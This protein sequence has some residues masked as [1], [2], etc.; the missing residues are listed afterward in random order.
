[1]F[2]SVLFYY[3]KSKRNATIF[4]DINTTVC[5][6]PVVHER[7]LGNHTHVSVRDRLPVGRNFIAEDPGPADRLLLKICGTF[8]MASDELEKLQKDW[9][10]V[11]QDPIL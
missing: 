11:H 10:N 8:P 6:L 4:L 9:H 7:N 3:Q 1:L 5:F 2:I